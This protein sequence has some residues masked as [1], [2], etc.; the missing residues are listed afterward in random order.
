MTD[1]YEF[2]DPADAEDGFY[3]HGD[4][5]A[6]SEAGE[7]VPQT[8][9]SPQET[10]PAGGQQQQAS[11]STQTG[12]PPE[13]GSPDLDSLKPFMNEDG[14]LR[15]ADLARHIT[16]T[17]SMQGRQ[18]NELGKLRSL[19]R[20][21]EDNRP[22]AKEAAGSQTQRQQQQQ[23]TQESHKE[24]KLPEGFKGLLQPDDIAFVAAMV[25]EIVKE[26]AGTAVRG[27]LTD[28]ARRSEDFQTRRIAEGIGERRDTL[29]SVLN[30]ALEYVGS[31]S[32]TYS[33]IPFKVVFEEVMSN[34]ENRA[35]IAA[36]VDQGNLEV[37]NE[38]IAHQIAIRTYANIINKAQNQASAHLQTQAGPQNTSPK[39]IPVQPQEEKPGGSRYTEAERELLGS[40]AS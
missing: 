28:L 10:P 23:Q 38:K 37:F 17:R 40:F 3:E 6:A 20:S 39:V 9:A 30:S 33:K 29:N 8:Q 2:L 4:T 25:R 5:P 19:M 12:N 7:T 32:P 21:W 34:P 16:A 26:G 13:D 24:F 15:T 18:A 27:E 22:P 36:Y 11:E 1:N 31:F 14:T 35:M